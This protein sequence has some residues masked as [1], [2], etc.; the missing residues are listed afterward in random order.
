MKIGIL[1]DLH[2]KTEGMQPRP[3]CDCDVM[4]LAGDISV[5]RAGIAWARDT[6]ECPIIYVPG[7]HEYYGR[8]IDKLDAELKAA[9]RDTNVHVLQN[10]A[11]VIEGIRFIG[12]TLWTDFNL[13]GT[14]NSSARLAQNLMNDYIVINTGDGDALE[15]TETIALHEQSIIYFE[16]ILATPFDGQT[17]VVTHH[18]PSERSVAPRFKGDPLSPCFASNLEKLVERS[19]AA[20]WIHGHVHDSF[21]YGIGQTRVV[22]NPKGYPGE[23]RERESAPFRWDFSVD[24]AT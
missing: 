15:P 18:A 23:D 20:L 24:V 8:R 12:A 5:G 7:N 2:L 11:V 10:D 14:P 4:V 17:V 3:S 16:H 13:Y 9:A 1:S 19:G 22:C 6:F 21:D